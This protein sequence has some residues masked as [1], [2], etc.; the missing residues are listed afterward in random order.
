MLLDAYK[1]VARR[2]GIC[3]AEVLQLNARNV[4]ENPGCML[5]RMPVRKRLFNIGSWLK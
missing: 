4:L 5:E 2:Y 3:A 1:T